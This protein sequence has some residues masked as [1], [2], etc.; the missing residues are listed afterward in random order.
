MDLLSTLSRDETARDAAV[1]C[2]CVR[3][4]AGFVEAPAAAKW[5]VVLVHL[6]Y[7]YG[8]AAIS[9]LL[10]SIGLF[11]KRALW[12]RRYSAEETYKF[13]E[14]TSHNHPIDL[15][16]CLALQTTSVFAE[17]AMAAKK[18]G[19]SVSFRIRS[20]SFF[21]FPLQFVDGPNVELLRGHMSYIPDI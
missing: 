12:K 7:T 3:I 5:V 4:L 20:F 17:A 1:A 21:F 10:K 8:V 19:F 18:F 6:S 9:R 14:H 16:S 2:D 15:F 11:C 13:E